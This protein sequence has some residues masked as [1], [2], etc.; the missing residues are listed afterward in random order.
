MPDLTNQQLLDSLNH[1]FDSL[2]ARLGSFEGRFNNVEGRLGSLEE[3][4]GGI[5][6]TV[7]T[8]AENMATQDELK[9]LSAKLDQQIRNDQSL[10]RILVQ[11]AAA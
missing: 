11:A 2:E 7:K 5:G 6:E 4:V 8:I 9:I 1:R 3:L 10:R